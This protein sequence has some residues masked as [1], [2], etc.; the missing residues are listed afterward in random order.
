M[1]INY[2]KVKNKEIFDEFSK[3][4]NLDVDNL[5]NYM[6]LYEKFFTLN[7][8]NYNSINLNNKY[9]IKTLIK[10]AN[11]NKYLGELTDQSNNYIERNIFF[12]FSPLIDPLKYLVGKYDESFNIYE[13]PSFIDTN[14]ENDNV[15][16]IIEK[17]SKI[18]DKNNVSYTD[19]F[20]SYLSSILLNKFNFLNGLD[21][22][23]IF[24]G[25]K[26]NFK[27][28][29]TDDLEY[30]EDSEF[31]HKNLDNKFLFDKNV[32][33]SK[34][35]NNTRKYKKE[36]KLENLDD[37][38]E[39]LED[40]IDLSIDSNELK[41][42]EKNLEKLELKL[43]YDIEEV[44]KK[45]SKSEL[46]DSETVSN[47]CKSKN[48]DGNSKRKTNETEKSCSSRSS[49]T[50]NSQ[51]TDTD[52]SDSEE[53]SESESSEDSQEEED[54][55][56]TIDKFPV[57]VI[58]LECCED[59]LDSYIVNSNK[60]KD[61]EWESIVLQIL[62]TLITYQ[63]TLKFTH[64]DLH[65]NNIVYVKTEKK[66]LYY[67]FN[68]KHYKIP[69]FGKIYKIIDFGRAIYT[70]KGEIICSD[71]Y[72]K[73]GDAYTQYNMEPYFN[74]NKA[75]LEPNYSF[76][77]CRLGCSLFDYFIDDLE[78]VAKVKSSIKKIMLSWVFDDKNRNILYKNNGEERYEDF[79]LYKMIART[80]HN[81]TPEKVLNNIVFE[82][83]II[84]KK[85]IN[86]QSSIFNIDELPSM[87]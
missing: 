3:K 10:R 39:L 85:K 75:R 4:E 13:M 30:L 82:N 36:L 62:F 56:C 50:E 20:F 14:S 44:D 83:Y 73:D 31:F 81:H 29:I 41:L 7:K 15:K 52:E 77:L 71:S 46:C 11:Y 26:N 28:D 8:S 63:K 37:N 32:N 6:P 86:N 54:I 87:Y 61:S 60:I 35:F 76:D 22:Y 72:S 79:K 64:N 69:T 65:T 55:F 47:T 49:N 42:T 1:S 18:Y 25:N 5:Q 2:I 16:E 40:I 27:V 53:E 74:E 33:I 78:D 66:Y 12:K 58:A 80:V 67:K 24:L 38:E 9:H 59:T 43:E 51:N 70:Y 48:T 21:F 84:A 45:T 19:G 34:I 68:G 17:Y 57:A 23:D